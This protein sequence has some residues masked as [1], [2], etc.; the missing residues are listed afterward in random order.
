MRRAREQR[1]NRWSAFEPKRRPDCLKRRDGEWRNEGLKQQ[2]L[3]LALQ[4]LA[5][6]GEGIRL[7]TRRPNEGNNARRHKGHRACRLRPRLSS[8]QPLRLRPRLCGQPGCLPRRKLLKDSLRHLS[9]V[10]AVDRRHSKSNPQRKVLVRTGLK[11][12][13]PTHSNAGRPSRHIGKA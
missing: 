10:S 11:T 13:F 1:G 6:V 9:L 2:Q 12:P 8:M 4:Q 5:E 7:Q 3:L